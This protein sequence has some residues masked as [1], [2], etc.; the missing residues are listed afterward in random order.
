VAGPLRR[1][2]VK[3]TTTTTGTGTLSLGGTSSTFRTL[4]GGVGNANTCH[5]C[6][7]HRT[8]NEWEEGTGTVTDASPDTL[9]RTT[10]LIGS[11]GTSLVNFSAGTKDVFVTMPAQRAMQMAADATYVGGI[12]YLNDDGNWEQLAGVTRK[13]LRGTNPASN[14]A[15][16]YAYPGSILLS[17]SSP[18]GASSVDFTLTG[19]TNSD[20][21][22]YCLVFKN[23]TPA[24]DNVELWI[25]TSTNGGSTFDAGA[26][27]YSWTRFTHTVDGTSAVSADTADDSAVVGGNIGNAANEQASGHVIIYRPSTAEYLEIEASMSYANASAVRA[28]STTTSWRLSAAD[29]DAIRFMASSGNISGEFRLYGVPNA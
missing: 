19:W 17:S 11:N 28:R 5:Y 25:R 9:S 21:F 4:V 10:V 15:P 1:S 23:V 2:R 22:T 20:F 7:V 14:A 3:E 26:S 24:T 27:D 8:A 13:F 29:V 12:P 6:V 18:S 16:E